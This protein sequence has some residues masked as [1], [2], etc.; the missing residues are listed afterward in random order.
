[1]SNSMVRIC[2][3]LEELGLVANVEHFEGMQSIVGGASYDDRDGV[4]LY[5]KK[6]QIS[7]DNG[8]Y[9][10]KLPLGQR[11]LE[12]TCKTEDQV[13]DGVAEHFIKYHPNV[14]IN[15]RHS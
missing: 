12:I 8:L 10:L 7:M 6:F 15:E 5:V 11:F 9:L 2:K 3:S 13:I 14:E 4:A 1:M